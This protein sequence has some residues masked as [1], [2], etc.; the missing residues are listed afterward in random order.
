MQKKSLYKLGV[1]ALATCMFVSCVDD[2]YDLDNVDMTI[3]TTG[4][5]TLPTSSTGEIILKN[6]MD[7]KEDGIIQ[8]IDGEFFLVEAYAATLG[9]FAH[10][11]FAGETLC[12]LGKEVYGFCAFALEQFFVY[13]EL[14]YA[15]EYVEKCLLVEFYEAFFG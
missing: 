8:T 10:L 11:A 4:D 2:K 5:L 9:E 12:V 13:F 3:G 14:W 7:L 6:L 15:A 1:F